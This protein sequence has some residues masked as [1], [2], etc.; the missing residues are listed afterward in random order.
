MSIKNIIKVLIYVS[1]LCLLYYL[2]KQNLFQIPLIYSYPAL[3]ISLLFLFAGFLFESWAWYESLKTIKTGA[4]FKTA[5]ISAGISVFAKYMPGKIWVIFGRVGFIKLTSKS[6]IAEL[7]WIFMIYQLITLLAG[8]AIGFIGVLLLGISTYIRITIAIA[9]IIIS[10]SFFSRSLQ[11][12]VLHWIKKL[13]KKN[14]VWFQINITDKIKIW[15]ICLMNWLCWG[16]GFY[17][18]VL[19]ITHFHT[20]STSIVFAFPFA[21]V[22]GFAAFFTPAGLG[23]REGIL[24]YY[25]NIAAIPTDHIT[26]ISVFSRLWFLTGETFM[27]ILA[28]ILKLIARKK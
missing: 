1:I 12:L 13:F 21:T 18:F 24:A 10:L 2:Y 25:L 19:S 26:S 5:L 7:S 8:M 14:F 4:S 16:I 23:I 28:Y 15:S 22:W 17:F 27:F 6:S 3:A 9:V 11:Q 20:I